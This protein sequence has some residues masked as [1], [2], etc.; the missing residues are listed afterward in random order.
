V[1]AHVFTS[2]TRA[3]LPYTTKTRRRAGDSNKTNKSA[4]CPVICV[5]QDD[6]VDGRLMTKTLACNTPLPQCHWGDELAAVQYST[7]LRN[8]LTDVHGIHYRIVI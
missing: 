1:F 2:N 6:R 8:E 3:L 4:D 7:Q 5:L